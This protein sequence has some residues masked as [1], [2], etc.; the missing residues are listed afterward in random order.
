MSAQAP[1]FISYK[2]GNPD[3][4][5]P[6]QLPL[7]LQLT[8]Y[9]GKQVPL[10]A[11]GWTAGGMCETDRREGGSNGGSRMLRKGFPKS[12]DACSVSPLSPSK[13]P[14]IYGQKEADVWLSNP[15]GGVARQAKENNISFS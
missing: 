2:T 14:P 15:T 6:C 3:V 7:L 10:P 11:S 12:T 4:Q 13:L 1:A 9:Y 8:R 5:S